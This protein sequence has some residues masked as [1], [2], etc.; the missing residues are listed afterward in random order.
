MPVVVQVNWLLHCWNSSPYV[1]I[2]LSLFCLNAIPS[3][4]LKETEE[5]LSTEDP[6]SWLDTGM[7]VSMTFRDEFQKE[8]K[9]GFKN[10]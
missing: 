8:E 10:K 9:E 1:L 2:F 7:I 4:V 6:W 5:A 3:A